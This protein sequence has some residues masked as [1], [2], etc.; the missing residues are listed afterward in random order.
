ME[1]FT[2]TTLD[3][4]QELFPAVHRLTVSDADTE[5]ELKGRLPHLFALH[6][7]LPQSYVLE[8]LTAIGVETSLLACCSGTLLQRGVDDLPLAPLLRRAEMRWSRRSTPSSS[9]LP[10]ELFLTQDTWSA[11]TVRI[12][13]ALIYQGA[14]SRDMVVAWLKTDDA[15]GRAVEHYVPV[16]YAFLDVCLANGTELPLEEYCSRHFSCLL[17][18][19]CD[20]Q[21]SRDIRFSAGVSVTVLMRLIPSGASLFLEK[22]VGAVRGI[23]VT[24]LHHDLLLIA[25]R[26]PE[27]YEIEARAFRTMLINHGVQWATR[28]FGGGEGDDRDLTI[29]ALSVYFVCRKRSTLTQLVC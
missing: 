9:D 13:S 2:P 15:T 14:L 7:T 28:V 21:K 22:C 24:A 18:V 5:L 12:V 8:E 26:L 16:L 10:V 6:H 23:S 29:E 19:V 11:S 27:G 17:G 3:L 4:L 1:M 25:R 20:D